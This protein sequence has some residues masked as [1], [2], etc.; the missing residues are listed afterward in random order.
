LENVEASKNPKHGWDTVWETRM[1]EKSTGNS[2]FEEVS[3]IPSA[4]SP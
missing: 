3:P 4:L 2:D 1:P